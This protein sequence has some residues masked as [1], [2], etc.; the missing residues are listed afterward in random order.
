MLHRDCEL[1][2]HHLCFPVLPPCR[3]F[4]VISDSIAPGGG[5]LHG[6]IYGACRG[7]RRHDSQAKS[8]NKLTKIL[9]ISLL[10]F[11]TACA[12]DSS[13][14]S[15]TTVQ[16]AQASPQETPARAGSQVCSEATG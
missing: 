4:P 2:T 16:T 13:R 11:L 14:K 7:G 6:G 8:M 3:W 10:L 5:S 1:I 15:T 9:Q 12:T